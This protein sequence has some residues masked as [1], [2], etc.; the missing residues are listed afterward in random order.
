VI[1]LDNNGQP[2]V[3]TSPSIAGCGGVIFTPD[4]ADRF[5]EMVVSNTQ[6]NMPFTSE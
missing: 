1:Y 4:V 5:M 3:E 6:A 2:Q